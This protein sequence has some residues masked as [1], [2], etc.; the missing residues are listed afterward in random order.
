V[1][2]RLADRLTELQAE[3]R[4]GHE[5]LARAERHRSELRDTVLRISGAVQVLEEL[6]AAES[7]PPATT[8][9]P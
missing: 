8:Q 1:N 5:E 3:L 4:K 2:A 6:A 7:G 9:R